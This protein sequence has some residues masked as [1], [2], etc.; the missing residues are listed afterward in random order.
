MQT[1]ST[2]EDD[3]NSESHVSGGDFDVYLLQ[4][5]RG[6]VSALDAESMTSSFRDVYEG[7]N[8]SHLVTSLEPN[9]Q[10]TLRVSGRSSDEMSWCPWSMPVT[11]STSLPRLGTYLSLAHE[12][13]VC[14]AG[15]VLAVRVVKQSDVHPPM[16]LFHSSVIL[17]NCP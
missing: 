15:H 7:S 2:G 13:L 11:W 3:N 12:L 14:Y 5:C 9:V 6:K 10:Y 17:R 16:C 1:S 4:L 8:T